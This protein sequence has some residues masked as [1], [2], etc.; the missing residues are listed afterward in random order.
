MSSANAPIAT[1]PPAGPAHT[2]TVEDTVIPVAAPHAATSPSVENPPPTETAPATETEPAWPKIAPA[3]VTRLQIR[4]IGVDAEVRPVDSARTGKTNAWG[5]EIYGAIDFPVDGIVRQWVRRGD[6]NTMP[7]AQSAADPKAFDRVVLYGHAS[8]IGN[9]LV[10][11]DLAAL[12]PG[13][14]IVATTENGTFTY[15]V[16]M[17]TTQAK[18]DLDNLAELYDYPASGAKEIALVACLPNTTSNAVAIGTLIAASV[19]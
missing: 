8:D 13:D 12:Q 3:S 18:S 16:T 10:F 5:G 17:T 14:S 1:A 4:A 9:H 2:A 11:Q 7:A 6:P 19:E 15:R